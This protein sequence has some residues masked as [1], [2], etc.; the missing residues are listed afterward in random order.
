MSMAL[1]PIVPGQRFRQFDG[2]DQEQ[3]VTVIRLDQDALG[4]SRIVFQVPGG[5]EICAY[6]TQI[7]AAIAAGELA[8]A[9]DWHAA[10]F[11]IEP[12]AKLAS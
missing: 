6:A 1:T 11:A 2:L 5:R 12:D 4:L 10:I 3:V 8:P 9:D 7:E